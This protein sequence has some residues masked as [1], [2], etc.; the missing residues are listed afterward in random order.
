MTAAFRERKR[1]CQNIVF[2]HGSRRLV[3]PPYRGDFDRQ[4]E[5]RHVA[6]RKGGVRRGR[7]EKADT[8]FPVS[9][10]NIGIVSF[11]L[12]P[13]RNQTNNTV[14]LKR[15]ELVRARERKGPPLPRKKAYRR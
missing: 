15:T 11:E 13:A 1:N 10:E 4:T 7:K 9:V 5:K 14:I 6:G 8:P 12:L 2:V 3:F